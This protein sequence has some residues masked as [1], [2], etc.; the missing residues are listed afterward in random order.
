[1]EQRRLGNERI[2]HNSPS[3]S[4]S[5]TA[6]SL[7]EE[8]VNTSGAAP[9]RTLA[10]VA[11]PMQLSFGSPPFDGTSIGRLMGDFIRTPIDSLRYLI[12]PPSSTPDL[13][14]SDA[15]HPFCASD[16]GLGGF[17]QGEK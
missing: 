3:H 10:R 6:D 9:S 4:Q 15:P 13:N 5:A 12:S 14:A 11:Y 7:S 2:V 17:C 16:N 8:R 1:M